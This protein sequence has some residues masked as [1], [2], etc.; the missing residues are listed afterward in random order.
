ME[1]DKTARSAISLGEATA[2]AVHDISNIIQAVLLRADYLSQALDL[3]GPNQKK[4]ELILEDSRFIGEILHAALEKSRHELSESLLTA[5]VAHIASTAAT[6]AVLRL[7]AAPAVAKADPA[8]ISDLFAL[9]MTEL[10]K[11]GDSST[12]ISV[13]VRAVDRPEAESIAPPWMA[14]KSWVMAE[15]RREGAGTKFGVD[16]ELHLARVP[17]ESIN[18]DALRIRGIIK[19]HMG[20]WK[21]RIGGDGGSV[22]F[23]VYLPA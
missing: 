4:M 6:G 10:R 14:D 8:L 15:F 19:L 3:S 13:E 20:F 7:P 12:E 22:A 11:G 1:S 2:G 5:D 21:V 9:V 17:V 23:R 18:F 16:E